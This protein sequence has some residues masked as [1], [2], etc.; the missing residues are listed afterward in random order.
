MGASAA[1]ESNTGFGSSNSIAAV[2][3]ITGSLG[4]A[5]GGVVVSFI[6]FLVQ[7]RRGLDP[8]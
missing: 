3:L 7:L 1:K 4:G 5:L 6:C 8:L 2:L